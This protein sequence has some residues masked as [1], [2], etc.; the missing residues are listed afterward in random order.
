MG[1]RKI[2][3]AFDPEQEGL[4]HKDNE[5]LPLPEHL[6]NE[7]GSLDNDTWLRGESKKVKLNKSKDGKRKKK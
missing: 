7:D 6:S 4:I 3:K 5:G 1:K 2:I